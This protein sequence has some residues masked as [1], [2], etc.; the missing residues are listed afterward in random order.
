MTRLYPR[1]LPGEVAGLFARL[2]GLQP[3]EIEALEPVRPGLVY[4]AA[5]GSRT[6]EADLVGLRSDLT[7]CAR[8]YGYPAVGRL[9]DLIAFDRTL[10]RWLHAEL[11]VAAGEAASRAVWAYIGLVIAPHVAAWR[12]PSR[13]A[14]YTKE[15]FDGTDLTRNTFSRLWWRAEVLRDDSLAEDSYVLLDAL[16][17]QAIDQLMARR[18][19]LAASPALARAIVRAARNRDDD[20]GRAL[21]RDALQRLL[22]L[23]AFVDFEAVGPADLDETV[24]EEFEASARALSQ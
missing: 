22:R 14:G 7:A 20:L 19:S 11:A 3:H 9:D 4:T 1:L 10:A 5:G 13:Q 8:E 15:R 12:F 2:E 17:E 6:E 18:R 23:S 21:F 24:E 16:G